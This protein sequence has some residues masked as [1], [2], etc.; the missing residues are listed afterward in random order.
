M[1]VTFSYRL[2]FACTQARRLWSGLRVCGDARSY[3]DFDGGGGHSHPVGFSVC[4]ARLRLAFGV[5]STLFASCVVATPVPVERV[6]ELAGGIASSVEVSSASGAA[7]RLAQAVPAGETKVSAV[8]S[9]NSDETAFY[10][11]D[12]GSAGGILPSAFPSA[13]MAVP[14]AFCLLGWKGPLP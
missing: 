6:R 7:L 11:I 2:R 4:G 8:A 9:T 1:V 13:Q 14:S 5:F 10:V 3:D 12:R